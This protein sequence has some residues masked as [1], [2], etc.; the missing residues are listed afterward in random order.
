MVASHP[1][2]VVS[3]GSGSAGNATAVSDGATTV[4]VDCGF[5]ARETAR[6]LASAG[7]AA[8][9][10]S[11][12]LVTHEHTDH[13][14][15]IDVFARRHAEDCSVY[16]TRGTQTRSVRDVAWGDAYTVLA[17]EA[18][19]IGTLDVLP[20]RTSHDAAEPVGYRIA[21]PG[22]AVGIA[23]DTGVLTD[24]AA[25]ALAG[26]DILC[27]ESNHDVRM[28]ETG[29]YPAFLKRRIRSAEGHL[30][31]SDAADAL[32]RLASDRLRTV[33]ALHRSRTNNTAE[34]AVST[35]EARARRIG[36]NVTVV[37]AA[38]H[39]I[40]DSRPPQASLFTG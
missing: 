35:L 1:L 19:R 10:V 32:E 22:S 39:D 27:L 29:P 31:N 9:S 30:S 20:F 14:R 21:S 5:S 15:G 12:L 13:V 26:V 36:L 6:R 17:G 7:I 3:L 23:T 33:L 24:E 34:L 28:L 37:V 38:Q 11:A 40:R 8:S 18:I 2:R 4:L 25:E 16:A